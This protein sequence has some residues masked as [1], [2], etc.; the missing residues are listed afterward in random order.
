MGSIQCCS[1]KF[2]AKAREAK[3]RA[4]SLFVSSEAF[5]PWQVRG[6]TTL[7]LPTFGGAC[8]Q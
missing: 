1:S 7:V 5:E 6:A 2:A 3:V 4:S 8:S